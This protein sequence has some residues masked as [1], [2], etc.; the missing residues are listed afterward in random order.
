[1][2]ARYD[3]HHIARYYDEYGEREWYRFDATVKD[4]V[5]FHVHRWYLQRFV[6]PGERVLEV[7]AGT[8][9]FTIELAKLGA[10]VTVGDISPVQLD[11]NRQKVQEAG[12][13]GNVAARRRVDIVDLSEFPSDSFDVVVAYGGPLS[14]VFDHA[15]QALKEL[16]RVAKP[17]GY[18][19]LSVMS[20]LGATRAF[21]SQIMQLA[22][23]IGLAEIERV[24][25]TG[26]LYGGE[27]AKTGH[28]CHMYRWAE[29]KAMLERHPCRLVAASSS[30]F[31]SVGNE[32]ALRDLVSDAKM[33]DAVFRWE[34]D[35]CKEGGALDGGTHIISVVCKETGG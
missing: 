1:M 20:L 32:E 2:S 16:L 27:V 18:V 14:Y 15:D 12:C 5:S 17:G 21:L 28:H 35:F 11:L 13:E 34:L 31:L 8:G 6:N 23:D 30:N 33:W 10:T 7:G 19:L 9:R 29:L 22:Q 4:K 25:T 24:N 26:I 3:P